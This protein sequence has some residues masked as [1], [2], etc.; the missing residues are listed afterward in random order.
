MLTDSLKKLLKQNPDRLLYREAFKSS[1]NQQAR[2][3]H[4]PGGLLL[5]VV[6]LGFAFNIDQKFHPFIPEVFILRI[7]LTILACILLFCI[8]LDRFFRINLRG[9]GLGLI[10][11]GGTYLTMA[12]AYITGRFADHAGY[13]AGMQGLI[14]LLAIVPFPLR[15]L[16]IIYIGSMIVFGT[17]L[18]YYAPELNTPE[19]SYSM[20]NL[21]IAY[22]LGFV[23]GFIL[24]HL[25]FNQVVT[26][27]KV[28]EQKRE[29]EDANQQLRQIDELKS[30]FIANVS[31]ELRTPLTM[32]LSPLEAVLQ[33]RP[34]QTSDQEFFSS[35]FRNGMRLLYLI[36]NLLDFSQVASGKSIIHVRK[37][38]LVKML[39]LYGGIV[40]STCKIR[41]IEFEYRREMQSLILYIDREKIDKAI[42]NLVSN[43]I[44]FTGT[45]GRINVHLSEDDLYCRLELEDSGI[46]I[47]PDKIGKIFDRFYQADP[48]FSREFEGTGI[49][50]SLVRDYILMHGGTISVSSIRQTD[51]DG[52]HGTKFLIKIPKGKEHFEGRDDVEFLTDEEISED[53]LDGRKSRWNLEELKITANDDAPNVPSSSAGQTTPESEKTVLVVDDNFDMRNYLRD[54]LGTEYRVLTAADG[55]D[56]LKIARDQRPDLI[57]ADVMMPRLNG[58]ELLKE[59]KKDNTLRCTPVILLT[60]LA[61]QSEKIIGLEYGADDFLVKPFRLRELQARVKTQIRIRE[62]QS[63]LL[64]NELRSKNEQIDNLYDNLFKVGKLKNLGELSFT[65]VHDMGQPITALNLSLE[66]LKEGI[67]VLNRPDLQRALKIFDSSLTKLNDL[68]TL[69][70]RYMQGDSIASDR[71]NLNV[72]IADMIRLLQMLVRKQGITII[73]ELDPALPPIAGNKMHVEQVLMNLSMNSIKAL[74][75]CP[76]RE[77]RI[78][79][80]S[81]TAERAELEISDSGCGLD[82]K[83][84]EKLETI[85]HSDAVIS[86]KFGFGYLILRRLALESMGCDINL[87]SAP[88][89]GLS[90]TMTFP[91]FSEHESVRT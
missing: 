87:R 49:G 47:P 6:W 34:K 28:E 73:T 38:D 67:K 16:Y 12:T 74:R 36:N 62:L 37:T 69:V 46:G 53:F 89:R 1:L 75:D 64:F 13:V 79:T 70:N 42:M 82:E 39:R 14:T 54:T 21:S 55:E 15:S 50:L 5:S 68:T 72:I 91:P 85:L 51:S 7:G 81:K 63:E 25:R 44:K 43:A 40:E 22:I 24:D 41:G 30:S 27:L 86:E 65:L 31:H 77:L 32:I 26:R 29:L 33:G 61:D 11:A 58:Y 8:F 88:G 84:K 59:V 9:K 52:E 83:L 45:G 71:L 19:G 20:Q 80:R 3:I 66:D 57:I 4:I 2:F 90:V 17:S 35:I 56:G 48:G 10:Y 18:Y 76:T 78:S 23:F 60:A